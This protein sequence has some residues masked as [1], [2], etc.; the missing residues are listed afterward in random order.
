[1]STI[2]TTSP[3]SDVTRQMPVPKP[4]KKSGPRR[5][6]NRPVV[7]SFCV[8][9]DQLLKMMIKLVTQATK[10]DLAKDA[11]TLVPMMTEIALHQSSMAAKIACTDTRTPMVGLSST[12]MAISTWSRSQNRVRSPG[13]KRT[14]AESRRECGL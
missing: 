3:K 11:D 2:R 14:M 9:T 8:D 4:R 10:H 6:K 12:I 7:L 1:M 5:Q 13:R